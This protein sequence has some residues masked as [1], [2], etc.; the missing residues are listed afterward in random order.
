[1][2]K[3]IYFKTESGTSFQNFHKGETFHDCPICKIQFYSI[4]AFN[5]HLT[6]CA[7]SNKCESIWRASTVFI[8]R[9]E[10]KYGAMQCGNISKNPLV[11]C[12]KCGFQQILERHYK[13]VHNTNFLKAKVF[14]FISN[15]KISK[16]LH[17][18][19]LSV[20]KLD[21]AGHGAYN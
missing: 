17:E 2:C 4:Q 21:F 9:I 15:S 20:F 10:T 1:M 14:F 19:L 11:S 18:Q 13:T 7:T 5:E 12:P 8:W 3:T 16:F 6:R